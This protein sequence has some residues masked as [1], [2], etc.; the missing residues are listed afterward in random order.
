MKSLI[1][2]V[3]VFIVVCA[4][5]V[6]R[7]ID[8]PN[9]Y[10][11]CVDSFSFLDAESRENRCSCAQ[12]VLISNRYSLALTKVPR[13]IEGLLNNKKTGVDVA[14]LSGFQRCAAIEQDAVK[15]KIENRLESDVRDKVFE[16]LKP[17]T[18]QNLQGITLQRYD[19]NVNETSSYKYEADVY[20]TVS[21][22][23]IGIV[24]HTNF[25]G[26]FYYYWNGEFATAEWK[27][28]SSQVNTDG[29]E[30]GVKKFMNLFE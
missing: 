13:M 15:T 8:A 7:L 3:I 27:R 16:W 11:K 30:Q 19:I 22:G 5:V 24:Q 25:Q 20:F 26:K 28:T 4:E 14:K 1:I 23:A 10:G 12:D 2:G 17:Q 18:R 9:Y 29:F 21:D 6:V